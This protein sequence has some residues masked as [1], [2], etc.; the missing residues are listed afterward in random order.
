MV[1]ILVFIF[2]IAEEAISIDRN[3]EIKDRIKGKGKKNETKKQRAK[4]KANY[5]CPRPG[6]CVRACVSLPLMTV[7]R[8]FF[9]CTLV[10]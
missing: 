7:S 3:N 6:V 5:I 4:G 1:V 9:L 2:I 10:V 8:L